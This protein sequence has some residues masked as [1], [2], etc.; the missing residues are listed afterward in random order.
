MGN[1]NGRHL[2][3]SSLTPSSSGSSSADEQHPPPLSSHEQASNKE[4]E[5]QKQLDTARRELE[6]ERQR[7][8]SCEAQ[9]QLTLAD[10]EREVGEYKHQL[11]MV[12]LSLGNE[13]RDWE[14]VRGRLES[15]VERERLNVR[16]RDVQ[17]HE[18]KLSKEQE[19]AA[20]SCQLSTL[21]HQL[22]SEN[23]QPREQR[24]KRDVVVST[25]PTQ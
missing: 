20:L 21:R 6:E 14:R 12:A 22:E 9:M 15:Q 11:D 16:A 10:V 5:L 23:R 25:Q 17:I 1:R 13:Y 3:S 18:L 4:R 19:T 7:L 2:L 24:A 8:W